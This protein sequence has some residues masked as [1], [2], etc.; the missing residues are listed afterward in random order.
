MKARNRPLSVAEV[1]A[2]FALYRKGVGSREVAERLDVSPT[3]VQRVV[4]REI[5]ADVLIE[6]ELVAAAQEAIKYN[7]ETMVGARVLSA[8]ERLEGIRR[9]L[10]GETCYAVSKDLGCNQT[11]IR[12]WVNKVKRLAEATAP[13]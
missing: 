10:G 1:V 5:H 2:I 6:P 9:V 4:T 3:S 7:K 13:N 11:A 12:W 8:E